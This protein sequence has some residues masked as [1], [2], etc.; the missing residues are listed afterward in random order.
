LFRI[1][2]VVV[3]PITPT[4]AFLHDHSA[5]RER[6]VDIDGVSYPYDDQLVW[7]GVA[8]LPGLPSTAA[9]I[10]RSASGLPIGIQIIGPYLEDRTTLS[11][12]QLI[13]RQFGGFR[14][15]TALAEGK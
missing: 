8:T 9:P 14:V 12:A 3:C 7:P 5:R 1:F 13:E 11:F 2:D 15:P 10:D 4:A 6:L